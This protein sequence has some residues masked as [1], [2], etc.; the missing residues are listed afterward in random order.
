MII[1]HCRFH[2]I[3]SSEA[4][5]DVQLV[6]RPGYIFRY[7][8]PTEPSWKNLVFGFRHVDVESEEARAV[9]AP[10]DCTD[11]W[12][13]ITYLLNCSNYLQWLLSLFVGYGGLVERR[14][15]ASLDE[16]HSYDIIINCTGLGS[17]ELVGDSTLQPARGQHILIEAPW[18][19]HFAVNIRDDNSGEMI[20]I[21]PRVSNIILGGCIE[22]GRSSEEIDVATRD[23]VLAGT[24]QLIPSL[25]KARIVNEWACHRPLR[26]KIC[27]ESTTTRRGTALIHCYGHGGQG[28]M[29]SWGCAMDVGNLVAQII[30]KQSSIAR[31][32]L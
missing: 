25:S 18:A 26:D 23:R 20:Y 6:L 28:G 9:N 19:S 1:A 8:S 12:A 14:R 5:A 10:P 16:L 30:K 21:Q 22:R 7:S 17:R 32:K 2:S 13:F 3:Y 11:I 15:I 27:L 31:S 4:N 24:K 29:L